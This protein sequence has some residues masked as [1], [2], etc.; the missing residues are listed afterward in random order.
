MVPVTAVLVVFV[1]VVAFAAAVL[2]TGAVVPITVVSAKVVSATVLMIS[3]GAVDEVVSAKVV[4]ATVLM[5][6]AG[7]VDVVTLSVLPSSPSPA[8]TSHPRSVNEHVHKDRPA[9]NPE[10]QGRCFILAAYYCAPGSQT[11][12]G[13]SWSF[14]LL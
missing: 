2:S 11:A 13:I 7:A 12:C 3:A 10:T 8:R 9:K 14:P 6:S 5:I 4:S 1:G